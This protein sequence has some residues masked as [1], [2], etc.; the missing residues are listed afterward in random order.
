MKDYSKF[1]KDVV[2]Y[3]HNSEKMTS[4]YL[5]LFLTLLRNRKNILKNRF[6]LKSPFYLFL[7]FVFLILHFKNVVKLFKR[8]ILEKL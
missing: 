3:P 5:N 6:L 2:K 1:K 8:R 4:E 7:N